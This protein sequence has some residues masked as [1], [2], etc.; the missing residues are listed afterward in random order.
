MCVLNHLFSPLIFNNYTIT[1]QSH[2]LAQ[3]FYQRYLSVDQLV[4]II[5]VNQVNNQ[6]SSRQGKAQGFWTLVYGIGT[7]FD[8]VLLGHGELHCFLHLAVQLDLRHLPDTQ[9]YFGLLSEPCTLTVGWVGGWVT[10]KILES[11]WSWIFVW[12]SDFG[13]GLVNSRD[14][15]KIDSRF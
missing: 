1:S 7:S 10:H 5:R 13:L 15:R 9:G 14:K 6:T 11:P 2:P 3:C 4:R 12:D 8:N